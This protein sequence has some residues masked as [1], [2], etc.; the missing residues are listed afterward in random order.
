M[1]LSSKSSLSSASRSA[2][3]VRGCGGG[4]DDDNA[5]DDNV[6]SESADDS[7]DYD[8]AA[9]NPTVPPSISG[10]PNLLLATMSSACSTNTQELRRLTRACAHIHTRM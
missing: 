4:I 9:D 10:T 5:D 1:T 6:E 8:D 3:D 2:F 7:N